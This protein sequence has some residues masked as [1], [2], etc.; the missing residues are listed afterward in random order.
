MHFGNSQ[1]QTGT[2]CL[3]FYQL[4]DLKLVFICRRR[5]WAGEMVLQVKCLPRKREGLTSV[6]QNPREKS[7]GVW[8]C[9]PVVPA[10][11]RKKMVDPGA[12]VPANVAEQQVSGENQR[13]CLKKQG[14]HV[15]GQH[16]RLISGLH[17]YNTHTHSISK[18]SNKCQ[19][20]WFHSAWSTCY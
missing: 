19:P 8:W 15:E 14:Q 2:T 4:S 20:L 9:T 16:Q 10:L 13:P 5:K 12:R 6:P 3:F 1:T 18:L 7:R 17:T 11:G